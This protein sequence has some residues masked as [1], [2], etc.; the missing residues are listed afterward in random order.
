[1]LQFTAEH[2]EYRRALVV[3]DDLRVEVMRDKRGLEKV[4][5]LRLP[6]EI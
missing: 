4:A 2:P 6:S 5:K 1:M 3:E